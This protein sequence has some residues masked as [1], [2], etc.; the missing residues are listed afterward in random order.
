MLQLLAG[1]THD[2]LTGIAVHRDREEVFDVV[3][4]RVHFL[5]LT[6]SEIRWYVETGEPFG[7]AGAYAIQGRGSRFVEWIEG[8]YSNVVGLPVAQAYGLLAKLG[9]SDPANHAAGWTT[10]RDRNR[11]ER[12][13]TD[14]L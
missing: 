9:W 3:R 10:A 1:R 6:D 2:V 7:K 8:S 5:P 13:L 14:R 11:S 4:T 12:P